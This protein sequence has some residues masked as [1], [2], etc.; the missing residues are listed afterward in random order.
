AA[1][2]FSVAFDACAGELDYADLTDFSGADVTPIHDL[3]LQMESVV[4]VWQGVT[5]GVDTAL[6]NA[7]SVFS[8]IQSTTS[9][10]TR[11]AC[12]YSHGTLLLL[13]GRIDDARR[14][15]DA[16]LELAQSCGDIRRQLSVYINNGVA[17]MEAGEPSVARH[18]L[19]KAATATNV[20]FRIRCYTNLAILHYE[21]GDVRLAVQAA[22][23]VL[24]M[25]ASYQS[26]S[27][28]STSYAILGL[29]ALA[30]HDFE[31]AK[32]YRASIND[33]SWHS[34]DDASYTAIFLSRLLVL[35]GK[36]SE[37]LM[38]LDDTVSNTRARNVLCTLR[39][40]VEK[41]GQ[42]VRSQP[43]TAYRL[44]KHIEQEAEALGAKRLLVRARDVL[45]QVRTQSS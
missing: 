38:V 5:K 24:S 3:Q 42:L 39:L 27:L 18:S 14:Q 21:E 30:Q 1:T 22:E 12:L 20:H 45:L 28:G 7:A 33:Q 4:L 29:V 36:E 26:P 34:L 43:D 41:A 31:G 6:N 2:L 23:S 40:E 13:A 8:R 15:L 16:A 35:A 11:A 17:L 44:A 9:P 32:M 10:R 25:N 19:E 37:A